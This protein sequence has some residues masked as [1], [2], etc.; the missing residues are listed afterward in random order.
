MLGK[1]RADFLNFFLRLKWMKPKN[2]NQNNSQK[3]T[4]EKKLKEK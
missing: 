2:L 1:N 3:P 4:T